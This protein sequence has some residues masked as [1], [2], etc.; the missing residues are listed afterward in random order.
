MESVCRQQLEQVNQQTTRYLNQKASEHHEERRTIKEL[1]QKQ[2]AKIT[3]LEQQISKDA[4][5]KRALD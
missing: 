4:A 3:E 5:D 2:K 1:V